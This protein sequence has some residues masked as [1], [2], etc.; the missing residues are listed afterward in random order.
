MA[1]DGVLRA[2]IIAARNG[3]SVADRCLK[4]QKIQSTILFL[5]AIARATT[6][7]VYINFR[8]EVHTRHLIT[9]LLRLEKRVVVPVTLIR[10]KQL[11]AVAINDVDQDC[12]PGFCS[13]LEP[14]TELREKQRV[15]GREIEAILL[16]GSVF[17]ELGGRLGY[18]GG[19]YD[20]YL[21][22][23]AP[24][25]RRIGLAF[26]LQVVNTL[27]LQPHDEVLD[28][29]VTEKRILAGKR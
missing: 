8:S 24:Q 23:E 19:Y 22:H 27:S 9:E 16:P 10:E 11:L 15:A 17:D 18:G 3:L 5:D 14:R 29:I 20:R 26:D 13:I 4:S 28:L 21:A 12:V 25:A 7:F 1:E 6:I 2:N